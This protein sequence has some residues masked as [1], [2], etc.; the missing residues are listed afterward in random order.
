MYV[1]G[2]LI[3]KHVYSYSVTV[4]HISQRRHDLDGSSV[5]KLEK[6]TSPFRVTVEVE[7]NRATDEEA[8]YNAASWQ[9][10]PY[11][12]A[13]PLTCFSS[14]VEEEEIKKMLGMYVTLKYSVRH[15][16]VIFG[17]YQNIS[18]HSMLG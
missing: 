13:T 18:A 14:R 3:Y 9:N 5:K 10:L 8:V 16:K 12:K 15:K 4:V 11:P 6:F 7:W 2:M 17:I 1:Y